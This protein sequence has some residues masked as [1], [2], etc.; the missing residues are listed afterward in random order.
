M[1]LQQLFADMDSVSS[2]IQKLREW[3][4]LA[5]SMTCESCD[6]PM[7]EGTMKK[8][9]GIEWQCRRRSCRINKSLRANSFFSGSRLTLQ[10]QLLFVHLW[11]QQ[12]PE[13]L[14]ARD[15]SYSPSTIVDWSRYCR[16]IALWYIETIYEN[17][18]IGG[19]GCKVEIDE[20]LLVRRKY[21]RGRLLS[22]EWLFGGVERRDDATCK[23][24]IEYVPDRT[25]ETLLSIIQR[26]IAPG[27]KILSD[28][29]AAYQ[30]LSTLGYEHE[31]VNH[32]INFV[33]Q[34]N[35]EIHTQNVEN[36][37]MLLKRFLRSKGTNRAPH[38]WEYICEFMFRK[39]YPQTFEAFI[40]VIS[41]RYPFTN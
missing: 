30:S 15:F 10:N 14:I 7:T 23:M 31:V 9:D 40:H 4:L 25:S 11:C 17:V 33:D 36:F 12:Y 32:S 1:K 20:T 35:R 28:G 41:L 39:L 21:N 27:T 26:R 19:L 8:A 3:S 22:Q 2:T 38:N 18:P 6:E 5:P 29:W 37:W 34:D 16:D 24:F 13:W